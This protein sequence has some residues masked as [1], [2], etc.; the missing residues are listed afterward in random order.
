M[1][2]PASPTPNK[3]QHAKPDYFT[4]AKRNPFKQRMTDAGRAKK[5]RTVTKNALERLTFALGNSTESDSKR[6]RPSLPYLLSIAAARV[7]SV[8]KGNGA[9]LKQ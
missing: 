9:F 2:K 5:H 7:E 3:A 8:G 6:K 4:E 1:K